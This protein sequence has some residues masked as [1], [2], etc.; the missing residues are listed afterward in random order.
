MKR[1]VEILRLRD[2]IIIFFV[3]FVDLLSHLR[4]LIKK[5]KRHLVN[6][7]SKDE[8]LRDCSIVL[9]VPPLGGIAIMFLELLLEKF[10]GYSTNAIVINILEIYFIEI[11]LLCALL[12]SIYNKRMNDNVGILSLSL[13]CLIFAFFIGILFFTITDFPSLMLAPAVILLIIFGVRGLIRY[14]QLRKKWNAFTRDVIEIKY[15]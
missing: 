4:S 14:Y 11:L 13:T 10:P 3:I 6:F 8:F 12:F 9:I 5:I 1:S 7:N 2:F 15:D